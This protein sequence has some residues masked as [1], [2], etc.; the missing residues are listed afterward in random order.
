MAR[1]PLKLP[2]QPKTK[3]QQLAARAEAV[4]KVVELLQEGS[5][6]AGELFAIVGGLRPTFSNYLNHMHKKLRLIR[7]TGEY[8][9]RGEVWELGADPALPTEDELLDQMFA[10]KR[11]RAP[12]QQMGM[13]RD[14]LVAALFGP[15]ASALREAA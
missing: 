14:P 6:T 10:V 13:R 5:K 1:G 12:A 11:A 7:M 3:G 9:N 4:A 2:F 15:A 8:R